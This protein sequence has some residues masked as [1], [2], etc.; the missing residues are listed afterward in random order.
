[1]RAGTLLAAGLIGVLF[2]TAAQALTQSR[3]PSA[4]ASNGAIGTEPWQNPGNATTSNDVRASAPLTG[5]ETSNYLVCTNYGFSIPFGSVINGI[6][7]DVER[8][9]S[10]VAAGG[11]RDAAMRIVQGG[12][13]GAAD[14]ATATLYTTADVTEA[15]GGAADLWGLAWTHSDINAANF[16][17]AFAARKNNPAQTHTIS[18]DVISITVDYTP[19]PR[20]VSI[21]RVNPTPTALPAVDWTVT[22][23]EPVSGVD[24]TDFALAVSGLGGTSIVSVSGG[25]TVYTVTANA[26][27][28][29]GT[30]GLNLVDDD[31]I[32]NAATLPL[33]SLSSADGGFTGQVYDVNRPPPVSS[34]DVVEPGGS[35]LTGRIFTKIAGQDIAV[36]IFALDASNAV[37]ASFTG[38]VIVELVDNTSGGACAGLPLIKAL[39]NQTFAAADNGRH[40]LDA[41][42]FEAEARRNVR[43]RI[44]Y[45]VAAPTVIACSSDAFAIRPHSFASVQARDQDRTT[46]G[47]TRVLGN[48]ADPGSGTV[49]NAG[50]PFR[51]DATARNGAAV[52]A[53]T[54]APTAT[55]RVPVGTSSVKPSVTPS[56]ARARNRSGSRSP[57]ATQPIGTI[58]ERTCE[59]C[60]F[61]EAG[62][63]LTPA[64]VKLGDDHVPEGIHGHVFDRMCRPVAARQVFV[65][66]H[67]GLVER[68]LAAASSNRPHRVV[69][70]PRVQVVQASGPRRSTA[71]SAVARWPPAGAARTGPERRRTPRAEAPRRPR[72]HAPAR[73]DA[74]RRSRPHRA[75]PHRPQ[76]PAAAAAESDGFTSLIPTTTVSS[77]GQT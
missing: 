12:L 15:H 2:A 18:V 65:G 52:P 60:H 70:A 69:L 75:P 64:L 4:C 56:S 16:G 13:I 48:T 46:A 74:G 50:R 7:V 55:S 38:A 76:Q 62:W 51:I 25:P 29:I 3:T 73:A 32:L 30:L 28:G 37:S 67:R 5:A 68:P 42:Q 6:T 9:T 41:G 43:F 17:A 22:F 34:F 53:T 23:T 47:T 61:A 8:R 14:R 66:H 1:M 27:T 49:H 31:S 36:D 11:S 40:P 77:P 54:S 19:P 57:T 20:V 10:S 45:P 21:N 71:L 26:G 35:P 58:A 72:S 63:T 59:H 24:V 33:A 39:A 44:R